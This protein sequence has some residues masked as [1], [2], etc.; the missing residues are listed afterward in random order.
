MQENS[1]QGEKFLYAKYPEIRT[2]VENKRS[3]ILDAKKDRTFLKAK[4]LVQDFLNQIQSLLSCDYAF[5]GYFAYFEQFLIQA[6]TLTPNTV[7][8]FLE[9]SELQSSD[10][11]LEKA[12]V[13]AEYFRIQKEGFQL[14]FQL[15]NRSDEFPTW[16]KYWCLRG[17]EKMAF[18]QH[19]KKFYKRKK[20]TCMDFPEIIPSA[21]YQSM[22]LIVNFV[23]NQVVPNS[24]DQLEYIFAK[25]YK[26]QKPDFA[27]L[28]KYFYDL[29]LQDF[30]SYYPNT[31]GIWIDY[32]QQEQFLDISKSLLNFPTAWCIK[33]PF[34]AYKML[35]H[36]NISIYYTQNHS[37]QFTIPRM[38]IV[39]SKNSTGPVVVSQFRGVENFQ[40]LD[41]F[42]YQERIYLDKFLS[43][44][45]EDDFLDS[46][47]QMLDGIEIIDQNFMKPNVKISKEVQDFFEL[48][49]QNKVLDYFSFISRT[50]IQD[51]FASVEIE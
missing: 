24:S 28:Y 27:D 2:V 9:L 51:F 29:S 37:N 49:I 43:L 30:R 19:Q 13:F 42:M 26:N 31:N 11:E 15:I 46:L 4:Y 3:L 5:E 34:Y 23:E 36:S 8:N 22:Q 1:Y 6:E 14:W 39:Y 17:L 20:S 16:A 25:A 35:R 50:R 32:T 44:P 18:D 7:F 38:A 40:T 47:D 48:V 45:L 10:Y 12:Y 21:Y 41:D 33:S